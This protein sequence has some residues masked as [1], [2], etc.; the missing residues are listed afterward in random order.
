MGGLDL[1]FRT[2]VQDEMFLRMPAKLLESVVQRDDLCVSE[3]CVFESILQ[4]VD[5]DRTSRYVTP[6]KY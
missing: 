3:M 1:A 4:W 2:V 5:A 6:L